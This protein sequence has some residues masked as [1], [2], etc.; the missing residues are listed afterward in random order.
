MVM[1][2]DVLILDEP[3]SQLDPI[4][5]GEFLKA[6][7]KVN[8]EIGTTII[9]SEH[10]LEDSFALADRVVVMNDGKVLCD[11]T[12]REVF[13]RVELLESV[14][15]DVPGPTKLLYMLKKD[16]RFSSLP[17][18]VVD[19]DEAAELISKVLKGRNKS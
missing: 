10:R 7:G 17:E 18:G 9:L 4:A 5:S 12:P 6:V 11:G 19:E 2:P 3:T 16:E 15:L 8:R 14:G 13:S 1:E